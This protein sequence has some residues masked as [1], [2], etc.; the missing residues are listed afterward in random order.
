MTKC[1][2][3]QGEIKASLSVIQA[4][5]ALRFRVEELEKE[6]ESTKLQLENLETRLHEA[7]Y[8]DDK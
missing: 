4:N 6:L 7:L 1:P 5:D 8:W 3:C 2:H